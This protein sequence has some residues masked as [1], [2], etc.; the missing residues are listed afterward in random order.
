MAPR[1][2]N[3]VVRTEPL[4]VRLPEFFPLTGPPPRTEDSGRALGTGAAP[5]PLLPHGDE[6]RS[7]V[8]PVHHN[9]ST[10]PRRHVGK[11]LT[12]FEQLRALADFDLVRIAIE[13]HKSQILGMVGE[14]RVQK[15][16]SEKS[17][18]LQPQIDLARSWLA[19]PDPLSGEDFQEWLGRCIEEVLVTDA[20]ALYPRFDLSGKPIGLQQIDGTTVLPLV[21]DLGRPPAPPA[22]AYQQV[23]HGRVETEFVLP[24]GDAGPEEL[25][26]L[27]RNRRPDSPYGRSNVEH[28]LM[29]INLALRHYTHD[30]AYFSTGSA[31]DSLFVLKPEGQT[32]Y[33]TVQLGELQDWLDDVLSGR[34]DRRAG[35]L[36]MMPH[37]EYVAT[38]EREWKYEFMEWL[39]RVVSWAF[40]VSPVPITRVMNRA[41]GETLESSSMEQGPRPMA[42]FLARAVLTPYIHRVL[43]FRELEFAWAED[44]TESAETVV[45]RNVRY[46]QSAIA[47][48]NEARIANG[49]DPY[50]PPEGTPPEEFW[51]NRP[52]VVTPSGV[53]FMD[54]ID[55]EQRRRAEQAAMLAA[56]LGGGGLPGPGAGGDD[57]PP[58]PKPGGKPPADAAEKGWAAAWRGWHDAVRADL[59]RWAAFSKRARSR[60]FA[61]TVLPPALRTLGPVAALARF[62]KAELPQPKGLE[63]AD[64]ALRALLQAWLDATLP[65]VAAWAVG[66]L[67]SGKAA[68]AGALAGSL[69]GVLAKEIPTQP[70]IDPEELFESL[71]T[72]LVDAYSTGAFDTAGA[73]LVEL[74]A[75]P[76]RSVLYAQERAAELVGMKW[77]GGQLVENPNPQWAIADTLRE[78][79]RGTVGQAVTEGWSPQK[80]T[81]A[82]ANQFGPWRAETIARAETAL[83]YGEGAADAY[84]EG[85]VQYVEILDGDGCLPSGHAKGSPA[86]SGT[87]GVVEEGAEANGQIWTVAQYRERKIGHPNCVRAAVPYFGEQAGEV[88]A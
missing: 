45:D 46:T 77:I 83:A 3:G 52:Y 20:L 82:L 48:V 55:E 7:V 6:P 11:Y 68:R 39:G 17:E 86:P 2:P 21:D 59:R 8:M 60:P 33:T 79:V 31:P 64:A 61:S 12:P 57:E 27:P 22:A 47:T 62:G 38:K 67:P 14:I 51:A 36:H 30:I 81:T 4:S 65:G 16:F 34:S 54:Q 53:T 44:E 26:Y 80:L 63:A 58:T 15:E 71:T 56:K 35:G 19:R 1:L 28:V 40:G 70:P 74:D 10:R 50:E 24:V 87:V 37:G 13:A 75:V 49:D 69:A 23:V 32:P 78:A 5:K 18:A 76:L 42:A 85:D 29:T 88:A 73:L 66:Q 43:G 25:W 41:T 9:M 84:T 72:I